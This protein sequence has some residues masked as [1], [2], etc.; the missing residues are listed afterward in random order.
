MSFDVKEPI[1][2]CCG[3]EATITYP[4]Y[5][6]NYYLCQ[7]CGE[8]CFNIHD[9]DEFNKEY[10]ND[11]IESSFDEECEEGQ[12]SVDYFTEWRKDNAY[13][14]EVPQHPFNSY[15]NFFGNNA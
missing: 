12:T 15:D 14:E 3:D 7:D 4:R 8:M 5:G 9:N 1:S 10:L 11:L 2:A 6:A 13:L